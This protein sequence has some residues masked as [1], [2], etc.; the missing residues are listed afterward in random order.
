MTTDFLSSS[1]LNVGQQRR[2]SVD[3]RPPRVLSLDV[4]HV[5]RLLTPLSDLF[6][7]SDRGGGGSVAHICVLGV[8]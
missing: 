5:L 2:K 7:G 3:V 6:R 1:R 8:P 4:R